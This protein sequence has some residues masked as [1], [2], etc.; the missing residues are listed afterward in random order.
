MSVARTMLYVVLF[1]AVF[2]GLLYLR[3]GGS[4]LQFLL[5]IGSGILP[6]GQPPISYSATATHTT[7]PSQQLPAEAGVHSLLFPDMRWGQMPIT[8]FVD[9]VSCPS[10][11]SSN[12]QAAAAEWQND[13]GSAVS[14]S[15]VSSKIEGKVHVQCVSE[16]S[17]S[18]PQREGV[19]VIETLGETR[20]TVVDT[21][22]YNL[23]TAAD[24]TFVLNTGRCTQGIVYLH[25]LGHVLG[26]GHDDDPQSIMF[27]Y[28]HCDQTITSSIVST[29]ERL[30]ADPALPDLY[31]TNVSALRHGFYADFNLSAYNRGLIATSPTKAVIDDGESELY[32]LNVPSL[33]PG[34]GWFFTLTN[35]PVT[36]DFANVSISVDPKNEINELN[37]ANN[38]VFLTKQ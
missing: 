20:P 37:K 23:T 2:F 27:A 19:R 22:L 11:V 1:F 26:L 7:T 32:S 38:V 28:E 16:L 4:T 33:N 29:I 15:F 8:I 21:G 17:P 31:L 24:V 12:L 18:A 13:T 10:E 30:Y 35:I 14:F 5:N 9:G 36:T 6:G 25:E 3:F 34:S